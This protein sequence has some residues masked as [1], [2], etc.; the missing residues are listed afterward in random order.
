M[1]NPMMSTEVGA[2]GII[3]AEHCLLRFQPG[4]PALRAER[5]SPGDLI[6]GDSRPCIPRPKHENSN[7]TIRDVVKLM[8]KV[9]QETGLRSGKTSKSDVRDRLLPTTFYFLPC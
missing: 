6:C 7:S 2:A 4:P 9:S 1:T 5:L 3:F 8:V